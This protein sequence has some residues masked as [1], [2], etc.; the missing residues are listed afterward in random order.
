MY[1]VELVR[2]K[3]TGTEFIYNEILE[4]HSVSEDIGWA[5]C[6]DELLSWANY[7]FTN[8]RELREHLLNR[9]VE[10]RSMGVNALKR[11]KQAIAYAFKLLSLTSTWDDNASINIDTC[12]PPCYG[13]KSSVK[14]DA[15]EKVTL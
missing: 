7:G 12:V 9:I 13:R 6:L 14:I 8:A 15:Q 1:S 5:L 11:E 3:E 4:M 10:I 2:I